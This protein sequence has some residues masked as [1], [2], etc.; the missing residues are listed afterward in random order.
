MSPFIDIDKLRYEDRIK[1][2]NTNTAQALVLPQTLQTQSIDNDIEDRKKR[3]LKFLKD[4]IKCIMITNT[5]KAKKEDNI[6][7]SFQ[8]TRKFIKFQIGTAETKKLYKYIFDTGESLLNNK[9]ID[10]E[11][12]FKYIKKM[13]KDILAKKIMAFEEKK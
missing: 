1:S 5:K 10:K 3:Y 9:P 8:L 6:D 2:M 4:D 12:I 13:D 11:Q 7:Y